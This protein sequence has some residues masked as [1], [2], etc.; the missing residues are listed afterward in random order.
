LDFANVE[1][2][3]TVEVKT[4]G[5]PLQKV[6]AILAKLKKG[7]ILHVSEEEKGTGC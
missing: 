3:Q 5:A 7:R 4:D 1:G 2:N 6:S